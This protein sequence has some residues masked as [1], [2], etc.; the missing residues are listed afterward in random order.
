MQ[1]TPFVCNH[2]EMNNVHFVFNVYSKRTEMSQWIENK[3]FITVSWP[4]ITTIT[5]TE[6]AFYNKIKKYPVTFDCKDI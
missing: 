2:L 4:Q 5:F 1:G 3:D 6:T